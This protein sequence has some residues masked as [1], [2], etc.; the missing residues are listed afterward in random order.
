MER[1]LQTHEG[2]QVMTI[3]IQLDIDNASFDD[4]EEIG[5]ILSGASESLV[6]WWENCGRGKPFEGIGYSNTLTDINGNTVGGI[7]TGEKLCH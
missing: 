2:G 4:P 7:T 1:T 6:Q 3:N 5:R